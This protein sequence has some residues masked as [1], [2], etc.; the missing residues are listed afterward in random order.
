MLIFDHFA[1]SAETLEDGVAAI[2]AALGLPMGPG[3]RHA[4]M[5]THNRLLGLGDL[6]L[7]VIAVDPAAPAP[8]HPRWF[9]LDGFSGGAR[10]TNWIARSN[11]LETALAAA[12]A[13]AGQP[14]QF[15]RDDLRWRMA[16]PAD[17]RLPFDNAFPALIQWQ[18]AAATTRHPT[19]RL[20][21]TGC[22]LRRLEIAHP[23][24]EALR[25]ALAPLIVEPR[26][27]VVPGPR[28]EMRAEID[29][30]HGRRRI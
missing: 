9:D 30:P 13:G 17:G 21:E 5:G 8:D 12:P 25:A 3:G 15:A 29:T 10:V 20:P 26:V 11:D 27:M 18:G 1:V 2:E 19:R 16:V 22:R 23:G 14:M 6:Y 24:A 28:P 7:E 4:R